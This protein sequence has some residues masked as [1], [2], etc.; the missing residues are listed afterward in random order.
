[1]TE[2]DQDQQTETPGGDGKEINDP[3]TRSDVE[4]PRKEFEGTKPE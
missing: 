4:A 3:L 2:K 1:M